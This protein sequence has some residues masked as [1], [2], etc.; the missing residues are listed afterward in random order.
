MYSIDPKSPK[1]VINGPYNLLHRRPLRI[2][3]FSEPT[4]H[5]VPVLVSLIIQYQP[6]LLLLFVSRSPY[7]EDKT[8]E[9]G[10]ISQ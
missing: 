5:Q 8:D 9:L 10:S 7:T 6:H 1:R 3:H 2:L 4:T